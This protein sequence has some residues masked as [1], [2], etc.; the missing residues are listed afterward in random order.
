MKKGDVA[1]LR[2][3]R[4]ESFTEVFLNKYLRRQGKPL[5]ITDKNYHIKCDKLG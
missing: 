4:R 5:V 2:K 3:V 1:V